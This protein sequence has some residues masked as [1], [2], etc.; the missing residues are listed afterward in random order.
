MYLTWIIGDWG[1]VLSILPALYVL[2]ATLLERALGP[3]RGPALVAW[4]GLA[5]LIVVAAGIAFVL[6]PGRW[7]QAMLR[8]HDQDTAAR[9]TYIRGH[10]P[11]DRTVLLARED[12]QQARYYLA[13]YRTWLYD[14][15]RS[16]SGDP[17]KDAAGTGVV[18]FTPDLVLRQPVATQSVSIGGGGRLLYVPAPAATIQLFGIDPIAREP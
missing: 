18:I 14:P 8:A 10:F 7:S 13:E 1:Y 6:L 3:A 2:C 9:V 17:K 5:A 16:K 11:S 15:A 4:R 12:Y